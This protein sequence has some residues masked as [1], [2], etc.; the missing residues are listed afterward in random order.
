MDKEYNLYDIELLRCSINDFSKFNITTRKKIE[1]TGKAWELKRMMEEISE[2]TH[3]IFLDP[4]WNYDFK[5]YYESVNYEFKKTKKEKLDNYLRMTIDRCIHELKSC[6]NI[7][8][9]IIK[10][11]LIPDPKYHGSF[12][13]QKQLKLR[14]KEGRA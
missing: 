7:E 8:H 10:G 13:S 6:I 5:N 14:I 9:Q 2:K 12:I 1:H 4:D 3:C 11:E